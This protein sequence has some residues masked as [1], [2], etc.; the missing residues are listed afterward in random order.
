MV[1]DIAYESLKLPGFVVSLA[2]KFLSGQIEK[3]VH[4]DILKLKPME[5]ARECSVPCVFIIGAEDKLVYPKRVQQIFD[6]YLGKQKSLITSMGDHSAEREPHILQQCYSLITKELKKNMAAPRATM[7]PPPLFVDNVTDDQL[8]VFAQSFS[9]RIEVNIL[10][11]EK[12]QK[13][14][15]QSDQGARVK[16]NFD[17]FLDETRNEE[18]FFKDQDDFN[19]QELLDYRNQ[20]RKNKLGGPSK[21]NLNDDE[22][23]SIKHMEGFNELGDITEA[24]FNENLN[25]LSMFL[26]SNKL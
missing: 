4:F 2:L 9:D 19:E 23:F 21:N 10:N 26:R 20:A 5:F 3:K 8:K 12:K 24:D 15:T 1:Q 7:E 6:S 13:N 22:S 25:D 17:V 11:S 18:N 14:R 16:I